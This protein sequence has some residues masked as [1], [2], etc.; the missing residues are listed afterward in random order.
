MAAQVNAIDDARVETTRPRYRP[1]EHKGLDVFGAK[2]CLAL[3]KRP[4]RQSPDR[5]EP[6]CRRSSVVERILG[7]AEVDSS[8]L[9]GGTIFPH[10]IQGL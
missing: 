6:A 5:E 1:T 10:E 4:G 3:S 9:S 8:I 7:K 2:E